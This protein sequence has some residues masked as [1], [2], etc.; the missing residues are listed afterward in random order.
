MVNDDIYRPHI[1]QLREYILTSH[2]H[3][4]S[5]SAIFL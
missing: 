1:A 3:N 5:T 4:F 2:A